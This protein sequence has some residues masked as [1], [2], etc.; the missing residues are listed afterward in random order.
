MDG[1]VG[2]TDVE[3]RS[4]AVVVEVGE[5]E[6]Y[7]LDELGEVDGCLGRSVGHF[8]AVPADDLDAPAPKRAAGL[9][10]LRAE[11]FGE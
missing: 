10:Q 4:D 3:Q 2:P 5:S 6:R 7:A 9:V 8:G 11:R 1:P